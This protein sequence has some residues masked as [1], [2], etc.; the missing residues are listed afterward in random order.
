MSHFVG[1]REVVRGAVKIIQH[2]CYASSVAQTPH[3]W[4]V[5][6]QKGRASES[7][8]GGAWKAPVCANVPGPK[9]ELPSTFLRE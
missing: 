4:I 2:A 3:P 5:E 9:E 7:P 1:D 6:I 8:R